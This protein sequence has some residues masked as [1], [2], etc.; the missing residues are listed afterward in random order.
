MYRLFPCITIFRGAEG[1]GGGWL[2]SVKRMCMCG[3]VKNCIVTC[4][5]FIF[6]CER[7]YKW[8]LALKHTTPV[9]AAVILLVYIKCAA[10]N[11][12]E[13]IVLCIHLTIMVYIVL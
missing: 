10:N 11:N 1:G 4:E 12:A 5:K 2:K 13:K 9:T 6:W 8:I 7:G 3:W